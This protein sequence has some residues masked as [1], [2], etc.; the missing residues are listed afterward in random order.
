M[1]DTP[2]RPDPQ[3]GAQPSA[4]PGG[5]IP[6]AAESEAAPDAAAEAAPGAAAARAAPETAAVETTPRA[7]AVEPAP[8]FGAT[9]SVPGG[10]AGEASPEAAA[11]AAR[12]EIAVAE[13]AP[14]AAAVKATPSAAAVEA[15]PGFRATGSIPGADEASPE[16]AASGAPEIVAA[17]TAPGAAATGAAPGAATVAAAPSAAAAEAA[18]EA[19]AV[20]ATLGGAATEAAPDAAASE[21]AP[22]IAAAE[23]APKAAPVAAATEASPDAAAVKATSGTAALEAAP[24]F[25]ATESV[26]NAGAGEAGPEAAASAAAPEIAAAEAAAPSVVESPGDMEAR[27]RPALEELDRERETLRG[28]FLFRIAVTV[29]GAGALA[30]VL[31]S[32]T[33]GALG[34]GLQS[35]V[36][37]PFYVV[38]PLTAVLLGYWAN[39]VR[40]RYVSAHKT[41]ILPAIANALGAFRYDETGNFDVQRLHGSTLLPSFGAYTSG[42]VFVG[43]YKGVDVELA[44]V[45]LFKDKRGGKSGGANTAFKGLF[46]F[47]STHRPI[48]G[49]TVVRRDAGP[50]G[51]WLAGTIGA[52]NRIRLQNPD[53]ERRYEIYT[54]DEAEARYLLTPAFMERLDALPADIGTDELQ[55]AFFGEHLLVMVAVAKTLFEPPSIFTSVLKDAGV[56]RIADEFR[57]VLAMIDGMALD[58]RTRV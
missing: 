4:S 23:A 42:N 7:S 11:S 37:E 29:L 32:A 55:A 14:G 39:R 1:T 46:I 44:E 34:A 28:E 38:P 10:S 15:V 45:E 31:G 12:P 56:A 6:G 33:V 35:L 26:P 21:A 43:S 9:G 2:D 54:T 8:G 30:M 50:I 27:L 13:A 25:D 16:A 5:A 49:K 57:D 17:E 18:P 52:L 22:G 36:S 41:V 3:E 51:N 58:E 53:L 19:V 24:G 40:R 47:L 20:Q 48:S